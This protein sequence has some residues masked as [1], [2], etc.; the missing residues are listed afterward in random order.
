MKNVSVYNESIFNIHKLSIHKIIRFLVKEFN[1]EILTLEINFVENETIQ[2][3]NKEYLNHNYSTDIITF[4]YSKESNR[5]DGEIFISLSEAGQNA[6]KYRVTLDIE[7]LRLIIHGILHMIGYDDIVK[8]DKLRMKNLEN[9][10]VH[11]F[12]INFNNG[13][14]MYD[15]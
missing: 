1:F 11:K 9:K 13:I 8:S 10:L 12:K 5:L 4:N 3:I 7:I 14:V 2:K 6:K 15:G